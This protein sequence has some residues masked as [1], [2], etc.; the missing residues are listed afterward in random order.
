[1]WEYEYNSQTD[2]TTWYWDDEERA[3]SDGKPTSWKNGRPTGG[4]RDAI[5]ESIQSAGTPER[6]EMMLDYTDSNFEER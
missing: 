1:M 5:H 2:E 4:H 3:T 6:I